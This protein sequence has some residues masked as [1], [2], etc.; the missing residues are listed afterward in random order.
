LLLEAKIKELLVIQLEHFLY[1]DPPSVKQTRAS[2]LP[3]D[4]GKLKEAK[5]IL[6]EQFTNPPLI[7]ALAR[8]VTLNEY[9]LKVGFKSHYNQ[10]IYQYVI[11]KKMKFALSLLKE[12]CLT[13]SEVA[14]KIGYRD[15]AHF[16]NAFLK[17]YGHRPTALASSGSVLNK[18]GAYE[19]I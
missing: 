8:M 14:Y 13:V 18:T 12:G 11:H 4:I 16:S 15:V 9:K 10:T 5:R 6:D 2:L 17:Y 1:H 7:A 3:S 19:T